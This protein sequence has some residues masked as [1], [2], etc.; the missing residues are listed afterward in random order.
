[1]DLLG[2]L[3]RRASPG[4]KIEVTDYI[5]PTEPHQLEAF[6]SKHDRV[7]EQLEILAARDD[8]L[9]G[10]SL[11]I[12]ERKKKYLLEVQKFKSYLRR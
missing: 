3:W 6:I 2:G 7:T 1:M 8:L 11:C 4:R 12:L 5:F 9:T 10:K